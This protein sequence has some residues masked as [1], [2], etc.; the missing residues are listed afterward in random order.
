MIIAIV[1]LSFCLA[2]NR[3]SMCEALHPESVTKNIEDDNNI[4]KDEK[5]VSNDENLNS[6]AID[7]A[8]SEDDSFFVNK[9]PVTEADIF[10]VDGM[11]F[12]SEGL[13]EEA[14]GNFKTA[15][16]LYENALHNEYMQK[17]ELIAIRENLKKMSKLLDNSPG[18]ESIEAEN[19]LIS[20]P[21]NPSK[22]P[23]VKH[24]GTNTAVQ[25][26]DNYKK[27]PTPTLKTA[28]IPTLFENKYDFGKAK[29]GEYW[30][31]ESTALLLSNPELLENSTSLL[32]NLIGGIR[33]GTT[34]QI[35][36][37]KDS[38]TGSRWNKV[39]VY[40]KMKKVYTKGWILS[41]TVGKAEQIKGLDIVT[42]VN[43]R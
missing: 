9:T 28:Q 32:G 25:V 21:I 7:I 18:D 14:V 4:V 36:E 12:M 15:T 16:D 8:L 27:E 39:Q 40:N 6:I 10:C 34:F 17:D 29:E 26:V 38:T 19:T 5:N 2:Y 20:S 35:L 1:F 24:I 22:F 13:R 31:I 37:T 43:D 23:N 30:I 33:P 3:V 41:D 11:T 42:I